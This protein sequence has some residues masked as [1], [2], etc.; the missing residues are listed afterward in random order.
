VGDEPKSDAE[1][2][3]G[4][5]DIQPEPT[6]RLLIRGRSLWIREWNPG[7]YSHE[8][9]Q[10][11][12]RRETPT[13]FLADLTR[14]ENSTGEPE[15]IV[16]P[17]AGRLTP[18]RRQLVT[19]WAGLCGYRRL[20]ATPEIVEFAVIRDPDAC[21][22]VRCPACNSHWRGEGPDFWITVSRHGLFPNTCG[23]CGGDLPQWT[24]FPR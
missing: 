10:I 18:G 5:G 12:H 21:A 23:L 2:D 20:W 7:F 6:F 11:L 22:Q 8:L 15:L 9:S 16:K 1:R 14:A 17:L 4:G 24:S 3:A 13:S 19:Q